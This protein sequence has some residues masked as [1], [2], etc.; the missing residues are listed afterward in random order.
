MW[1]EEI[2]IGWRAWTTCFAKWDRYHCLAMPLSPCSTLSHIFLQRNIANLH[3]NPSLFYDDTYS[4]GEKGFYHQIDSQTF[5]DDA[6]MKTAN[7]WVIFRRL[8]FIVYRRHPKTCA[9]F[10]SITS[11]LPLHY[12]ISFITLSNFW[13]FIICSWY[14]IY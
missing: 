3:R 6:T 14:L 4:S 8:H 5:V 12:I 9:F 1:P 10:I 2:L 11:I 7:A 13:L